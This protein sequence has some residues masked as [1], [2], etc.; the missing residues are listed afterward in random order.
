[1][2]FNV[3]AA[4]MLPVTGIIAAERSIPAFD[5]INTNP[6]SN[7]NPLTLSLTLTLTQPNSK[8]RTTVIEIVIKIAMLI[9][10]LLRNSLLAYHFNICCGDR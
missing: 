3:K 8:F 4:Y 9:S 6:G 1:M 2:I 10:Y 5:S 7:P